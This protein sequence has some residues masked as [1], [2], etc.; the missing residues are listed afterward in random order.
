[1][2]MLVLLVGAT[3]VLVGVAV[4]VRLRNDRRGHAGDD[5]TDN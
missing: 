5:E 3:G 1:M 4:A 2:S